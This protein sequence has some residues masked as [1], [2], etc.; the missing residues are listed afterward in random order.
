MNLVSNVFETDPTNSRA[1]HIIMNGTVA[2]QAVAIN[3]NVYK[4]VTSNHSRFRDGPASTYTFATWQAV[5]GTPDANSLNAD[6]LFAATVAA[7]MADYYRIQNTA[8][9]AKTVGGTNLF[10]SGV[11]KDFRARDRLS[12]GAWQA[13]AFLVG[14]AAGGRV[15]GGVMM[16]L[17]D[18]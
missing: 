18:G 13:G 9:P 10:A 8:S 6:P 11:S 2:V 7:T 3:R 1:Y 15:G 4:P 12:T 5:V 14:L 16:L 17:L